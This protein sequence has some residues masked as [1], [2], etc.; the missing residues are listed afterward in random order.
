KF[1]RFLTFISPNCNALDFFSR[2]N[3]SESLTVEKLALERAKRGGEIYNMAITRILEERKKSFKR[4]EWFSKLIVQEYEPQ[5]VGAKINISKEETDR[6]SACCGAGNLDVGAEESLKETEG[7]CA[8]NARELAT[9]NAADR[10]GRSLRNSS[11]LLS[12]ALLQLKTMRQ[13]LQIGFENAEQDQLIAKKKKKKK[14]RR[15]KV[16]CKTAQLKQD[17]REKSGNL[18]RFNEELLQAKGE[19]I[20][21]NPKSKDLQQ[22]S[23]EVEVATSKLKAA[24]LLHAW[25]PKAFEL[26]AKH[27]P[28]PPRGDALGAFGV[29]IL[30]SEGLRG[31]P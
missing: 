12:V 17:L 8:W 13:N 21:L 24:K 28:A 19:T 31:T 23:N 4:K 22:D 9:R 15:R 3:Q 25:N 5:L 14:R 20:N 26:L 7:H 11:V 27:L 30:G 1:A 6:D 29:N 18:R 16:H 2:A 10:L